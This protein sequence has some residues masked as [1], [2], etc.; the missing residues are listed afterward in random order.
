M[1]IRMYDVSH[2]KLH[3]AMPRLRGHH[4]RLLRGHRSR[5]R[6]HGRNVVEWDY[7][8]SKSY[9]CQLLHLN[10]YPTTMNMMFID[11]MGVAIQLPKL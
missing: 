1:H 3:G 5:L 9:A 6:M 2:A 11:L 8:E 7:I 4:A 10:G